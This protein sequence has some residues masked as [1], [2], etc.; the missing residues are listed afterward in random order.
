VRGLR[1]TISFIQSVG[2]L[3][4]FLFFL[5][6]LLMAQNVKQ[7]V[8]AD[9]VETKKAL[10]SPIKYTGVLYKSGNHRDPFLNPLL[11]KKELNVD[12]EIARGVPPPGI[13]GTYISQAALQG[14]AIREDERVAVVRGAD[15][16]AYFIREGDRFFDG[17]V[18]AIEIDSVTLVRETRMRSGKTLTQDVV[19]RLRTP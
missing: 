6:N 14:T 18:K 2:V 1:K 5:F 3:L 8:G 11:F 13:A 7:S 16:R 12:E 19:K 9:A 10:E 15:H 17:Y 4:T